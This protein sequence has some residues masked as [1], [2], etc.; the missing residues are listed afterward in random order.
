[1]SVDTDLLEELK[2]DRQNAR[3][4]PPILSIK[5][6]QKKRIRVLPG[7]FG[8]SKKKWFV[9]VTEHWLETPRGKSSPFTCV[10]Q[11]YGEECPVC[12][13]WEEAKLQLQNLEDEY[14]ESRDGK[15][16]QKIK[17]VKSLIRK[18]SY[19]TAY[20]MNVIDRDDRTPE[21]LIYTA[22]KTVW[23]QICSEF[24]NA[25]ENEGLDLFDPKDGF[26]LW[27]E[28]GLQEDRTVY[29]VTTAKRSSPLADESDIARIL[30]KRH[31]LENAEEFYPKPNIRELEDAIAH[32]SK[33]NTIAA[34]SS[35]S[36]DKEGGWG[37]KNSDRGGRNNSSRDEEDE[38]SPPSGVRGSKRD[39]ERHEEPTSPKRGGSI[40]NQQL[41]DDDDEEMTAP[42]R[43][44]SIRNQ[45]L[46]DDDDDDEEMTVPIKRGGGG[47]ETTSRLASRFGS[48][49]DE[50]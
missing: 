41:M 21:P 44:G 32:T 27:I 39:R 4:G 12:Q 46:M 49:D 6:K 13:A 42:K 38:E 47:S 16:A 1:M 45:Q 17:S 48:L 33:L 20:K 7:N 43:G 9:Q 37:D 23:T 11:Q 22:P 5:D 19:R 34:R 29:T 24:M 25:A 18:L 14:N 50:D 10:K 8:R 2:G 28:R 35:R 30:K 40:R 26:D 31:N 3:T 15:V 36:N